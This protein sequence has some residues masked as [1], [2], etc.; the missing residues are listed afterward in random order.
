MFYTGRPD[1]L[2]GFCVAFRLEALRRCV[3]PT[4]LGS[5]NIPSLTT[6][7]TE[8]SVVRDFPIYQSRIFQD[9]CLNVVVVETWQF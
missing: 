1:S 2:I 3:V 6:I 7:M 9:P 8:S 4:S 5:H